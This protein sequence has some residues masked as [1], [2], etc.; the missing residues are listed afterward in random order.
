METDTNPVRM[1]ASGCQTLSTCHGWAWRRGCCETRG[2]LVRL[3]GATGCIWPAVAEAGT[4][5]G[6]RA[7]VRVGVVAPAVLFA[8]AS[9]PT[10]LSLIDIQQT[11]LSTTQHR[12]TAPRA[13]H[14]DNTNHSSTI[15]L[16]TRHKHPLD[17]RQTTRPTITPS[18]KHELDSLAAPSTQS[19]CIHGR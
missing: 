2:G 18:A 12:P 1:T 5:V 17:A 3:A 16:T 7:R 11:T 14:A 4:R 13:H 10:F 15:T 9:K 8:C 6:S 19:P